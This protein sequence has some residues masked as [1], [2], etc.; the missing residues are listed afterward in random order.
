MI[1]KLKVRSSHRFPRANTSTSPIPI[2]F[3]LSLII[4]F[5]P[6]PAMFSKHGLYAFVHGKR[7]GDAKPPP[8]LRFRSSSFFIIGTISLAV[9]TVRIPQTLA[10]VLILTSE[11][12]HLSLLAGSSRA[13]IRFDGESRRRGEGCPEMD[14]YLSQ[15][16]W[17]CLGCGL[18]YVQFVQL[19]SAARSDTT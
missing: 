9:F 3:D 8:F 16:L 10:L 13:S 6:S 18:P 1:T 14:F 4:C 7:I 5:N 11:L 12:G 19:T 15:C 2:S 17:S